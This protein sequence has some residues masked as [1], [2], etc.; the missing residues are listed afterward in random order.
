MQKSLDSPRDAVGVFQ[1]KSVTG[2]FNQADFNIRKQSQQVAGG[3]RRHQPVQAGEQVQL[4]AAIR[5]QGF[6]GVELGEQFK[7]GHQYT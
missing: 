3:L 6:A 5:Q 7:A 1:K 4:R 2:L